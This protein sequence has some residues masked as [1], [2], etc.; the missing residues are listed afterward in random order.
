M[1]NLSR[2]ITMT[3]A[4]TLL[5][6][7][8][9]VSAQDWPQWRGPNRDN[10]IIGFAEPKIWPKELTKKWKVDVG[11]GESSPVLVGDK[12]YTFGRQ[13]G[14]E[15]TLCLDAGTGKEIWKD[16]YATAAVKGAASP[17][18]GTR[19]TPA[20]GEGKIC[21]LGVNGVVSC[22][23]AASG[24]M[25]W[26]KDTAKPKFYTST[27]P[28]I[29]DGKCIVFGESLTAF[30]LGAGAVKWTAA[31]GGAPYGSPVLMTADGIKM[32]VTPTGGN[33]LDGISLAD[34]KVLWQVKLGGG[35]YQA[36][37]STPLIDG[38]NVFY[39][40]SGGKGGGGGMLAL[41]IEKKGDAFTATELWKKPL[42]AAGYHTPLVDDGL[43]FGVSP[44]KTF[45]CMDAKTGTQLW[46]DKTPRGNCGSI[47]SAGRVLLSLTS[48]KELVAFKSSGKGYEELAKYPVAESWTVPIVTGNRIYVKDKSGSLTLFTIE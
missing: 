16:K 48:D 14:D 8:A 4:C 21:T 3:F 34:G 17:Y 45:F 38:Q 44:G 26:R 41:K 37:Y 47:L 13:G 7:A 20:V 27:S 25:L 19:S 2:T 5:F 42:A 18:P 39:S 31:G 1:N 35:G 30:D 9:D 6:G 10:K 28:M 23:D 24:K 11:I 12:L 36:N 33:N 40:I 29:A 43:I 15:V 46:A 22:L 32:I